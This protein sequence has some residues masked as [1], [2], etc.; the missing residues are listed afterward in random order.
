M[1]IALVSQPWARAWPPS[2]SIAIWNLE[3]GRRLQEAGHEVAIWAPALDAGPQAGP[4]PVHH[5][6]IA[7]DWRAQKLLAP[8]APRLPRRRPLFA[9]PVFHAEY[10]ARTAAGIR[11]FAPDAIHLHNFAQWAPLLR[12]AHPRAGLAL[13]MHCH[14]LSQ[15]HPAPMRRRA[16][17]ADLI[18]GASDDVTAR[19]RA[20]LPSLAKRCHTVPNGVDPGRFAPEPKRGSGLRIVAIG[21][22]SPEKG[23][24][25]LLEAFAAVH[26]RHP[27]AQLELVGAE[28][29]VPLDMLIGIEDDPVIRALDRFPEQGYLARALAAL[30]PAAR[31]RVTLTGAIEH[32]DVPARLARADVLVAAS[33]S[34]A[35]GMPV[36]EAMAAGVAVVATD[37]GGMREI[38][39]DGVDGLSV[40]RDDAGALAGAVLR[41]AEDPALRERLAAAGRRTA[42]GRYAWDVV[43][44][45][46]LALYGILPRR[47]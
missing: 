45:R 26:G 14:W 13:H 2:D 36:I 47:A 40:P 23:V 6:E 38:V 43:V 22:I 21:R 31:E 1:R 37:A 28:A 5:V 24:H 15:L 11:R 32:D 17:R 46:L 27:E 42:A 30:A 44:E 29:P 25:R 34:E 19:N 39:S 33:L 4:V 18:L 3:V 12:R 35:F 16:A 41:L 20:A 7:N 8:L 9:S 10:A